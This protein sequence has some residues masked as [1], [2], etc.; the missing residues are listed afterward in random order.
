MLHKRTIVS[1]VISNKAFEILHL[2]GEEGQVAPE[3]QLRLLLG[4][5]RF[6]SSEKNTIFPV[7]TNIA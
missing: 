5:A 3:Y 4:E 1:P 6:P 7:H 2:A